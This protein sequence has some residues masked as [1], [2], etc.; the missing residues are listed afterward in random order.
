MFPRVKQVRYL[1]D[2]R[3]ELVFADGVTGELDF[4]ERVVGRGGMFAP[5]EDV[6]F[7]KQ[8]QVDAEAGTLVW[9]NGVDLCPDVLYSQV[10][11]KPIR[12]EREAQ[13]LTSRSKRSRR[14]EPSGSSV[15]AV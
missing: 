14:L 8:V 4:R 11:G 7:F 13:S 9:P 12:F 15:A 10:T 5:L 2:Y 1:S 6:E 3:L